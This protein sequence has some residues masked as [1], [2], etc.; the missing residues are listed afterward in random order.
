MPISIYLIEIV[1][2][3]DDAGLHPPNASHKTIVMTLRCR[4]PALDVPL[5]IGI[6]IERSPGFP[7]QLDPSMKTPTSW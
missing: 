4:K 5:L 7:T 1:E 6:G 3:W 2:I